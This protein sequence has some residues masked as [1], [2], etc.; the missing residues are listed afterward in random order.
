LIL[1][2]DDETANR[3]L[4]RELLEPHGYAVV[5]AA[6]GED[7]LARAREARPDVI[8]LDVM[9]PKL[10]GFEVCRR[11]KAAPETR[12]VPVLIVSSL[13]ARQERLSGIEAGA[14]DFVTKP[15][16]RA[17]LLLRVR[18]AL[19]SKRLYD[20]MEAQYVRL[21]ELESLRDSLVHMLV[22]DV[23]SPL[24]ALMAY[25]HLLGMEL[26]SSTVDET[27]QTVIELQTLARRMSD[28]VDTVLDV[29]RLEAG[30]MPL[31]R[32]E[33]DLRALIQEAVRILGPAALQRVRIEAPDQ[34]T[35]AVLDR[36]V[37][38][39]VMINLIGNALKFSDGTVP[40]VV[41]LAADESD[42][43]IEVRDSG[44][45]I[46]D[47]EIG[48]IFEKFGRSRSHQRNHGTGLGLTFCRMA[49]DAH[50]GAIGVRSA[51]GE[52]STFW[53]RMPRVRSAVM[54]AS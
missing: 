31:E 6:N 1:V 17:D 19:A 41:A 5:E 15:I 49:V 54:A 52:G 20:D 43:E 33:V 7:G 39:R 53:F 34:P 13:S 8:L 26:G 50:G 29:N 37:I 16:D 12:V 22:H 27:A 32:R 46:P 3:L 24:G 14:N 21:R 25:L 47:D 10:D 45:G 42:I 44:P 48:H 18:N 35:R 23:R 11:L 2:V 4:L 36:D 40:V 51:G 28:M 38:G 9:M 30:Q